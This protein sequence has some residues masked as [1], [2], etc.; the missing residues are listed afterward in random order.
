MAL[1]IDREVAAMRRMTVAQLQA[2]YAEVF[3]EQPRGRHRQWLLRRI[4]WRIQAQAEGDLSDR[5][6]QRAQELANDADLRLTPPAGHRIQPNRDRHSSSAHAPQPDARLPMAGTLLTR[7]YKGRTV[8][9]KVLSDGFEFEGR[10][11]PSLSAVAKT[12]TGSHWNG[13]HFFGLTKQEARV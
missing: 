4:A 5:A 9:V 11:W 2:K 10:A 13:F 8:V 7:D 1:D 6:R 3:S 12:V